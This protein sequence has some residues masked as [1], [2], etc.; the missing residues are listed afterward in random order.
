M[1]QSRKEHQIG[2]KLVGVGQLIIQSWASVTEE[3]KG[4]MEW[5]IIKNGVSD[6]FT[7]K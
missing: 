7:K 3:N 4:S 1:Q 5:E 2:Q 6:K